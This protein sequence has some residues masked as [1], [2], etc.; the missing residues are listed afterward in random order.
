MMTSAYARGV[1]WA[2]SAALNLVM[3]LEDQPEE[4]AIAP[5]TP[6]RDLEAELLQGLPAAPMRALGADDGCSAAQARELRSDCEALL[7]QRS[8]LRAQ[9]IA[10]QERRERAEAELVSLGA[11]WL[12]TDTQEALRRRAE[13]ERQRE[14][15]ACRTE[16]Q[17]EADRQ[18]AKLRAENAILLQR[19]GD[20]APTALELRLQLRAALQAELEGERREAQEAVAAHLKS[21]IDDNRALTAALRSA[22]ATHRAELEMLRC[23]VRKA[24]EIMQEQY[25]K[26]FVNGL[27]QAASALSES[28]K[29]P[30][31]MDI[32]TTTLV[33]APVAKSTL[34]GTDSGSG[35]AAEAAHS[36]PL[37]S[38]GSTSVSTAAAA[39]THSCGSEPETYGAGVGVGTASTASNGDGSRSS[40]EVD[41]LTGGGPVSCGGTPT[42]DTEPRVV[43]ASPVPASGLL[44]GLS[45]RSGTD[46]GA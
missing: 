36:Q 35:D 18:I 2:E 42:L 37:L 25:D 46:R 30:V 17:R 7:Q 34:H 20:E 14:L 9:L 8:H 41:A 32:V 31:T 3:A 23:S 38:C 44:R 12:G 5:A 11:Q 27:K 40:T 43:D 22:E 1:Q 10:E 19:L 28:S 24:S 45:L 6:S 13:S 21:V 39:E 4:R 33:D 26:G 29:D 16:I 15:D